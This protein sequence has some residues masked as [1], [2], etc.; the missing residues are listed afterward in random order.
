MTNRLFIQAFSSEIVTQN[1]STFAASRSYRSRSMKRVLSLVTAILLS[2]VVSAQQLIWHEDFESTPSPAWTLNST[3]SNSTS[4]GENEWV[5]NNTYT[6]P[7]TPAVVPA[8]PNQPAFFSGGVNS[9]YLHISS[10]AARLSSQ[11]QNAHYSYITAP[12]ATEKYFSKM[13]TGI[14]TANYISVYIKFYFLN[15]ADGPGGTSGQLYYSTNGGANWIFVK[16]Y[17]N[18]GTWT[19]DSVYNPAFDNQNDLRF[20]FRYENP[21]SG[22]NPAFSVDEISLIGTPSSI[23]TPDFSANSTS[24]CEGQCIS[25][26]DLSG[27]FPTA[28]EWSFAGAD[29]LTSNQQNPTNIC[30]QTAGTYDVQLKVTNS[31]GEDSVLKVGYIDV[32][33]CSTP[34]TANFTVRSRVICAGDTVSY[35]DKSTNNPTEW[36]WFFP[37]SDSANSTQQNPTNIRYSIPGKYEVT[38]IVKNVGGTDVKTVRNYIEV[39]DCVLP[40]PV[41]KSNDN[42]DSICINT[43]VT[44]S[45]DTDSGDI[46]RVNTFEWF[47]FGIDTSRLDTSIYDPDSLVFNK[48]Q[49]TVCYNKIGRYTVR[50]IVANQFGVEVKDQFNFIT[51]GGPPTVQILDSTTHRVFKGNT[52]P[53]RGEGTGDK[54]FWGYKEGVDN[55]GNVIFKFESDEFVLA[56]DTGY[57]RIPDWTSRETEIL[58]HGDRWFYLLNENRY[59]CRSFDSLFVDVINEYYVGVPDIFSPNADGYNDRLRVR[60]NGIA[61]INFSVFDR[62]GVCVYETEDLVEALEKGWDGTKDEKEL[63]PGVFVYVA[64]VTLLDGEFRELVGNVTLV[65]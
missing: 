55:S 40:I 32:S 18:I 21:A 27:F 6:G 31:V 47:F 2:S 43:C 28:W 34:P 4:A 7:T 29:S 26:T 15:L 24:I 63:N 23:P 45:Y 60:G 11:P 1:L 48:P 17:T 54:F 36:T 39:Q 50:L 62:Y 61:K 19:V 37:G 49:H 5:I 30:Y 44:I 16:S 13:A 58:T 3:D 53:A 56:R 41:F 12:A 57:V 64:K 8:T 10:V 35:S 25:F 51:V 52:T 38:L 20:A 22:T 33:D 9:T 14:S 59:G 42:N 46:D 65:R